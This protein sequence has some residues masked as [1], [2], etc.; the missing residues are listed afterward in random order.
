M[1][2]KGRRLAIR[3]PFYKLFQD[4]KAGIRVDDPEEVRTVRKLVDAHALL[5]V[6]ACAACIADQV[7][8]G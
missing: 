5:F 4:G 7:G 1:Y 6:K 2:R 3:E 8:S